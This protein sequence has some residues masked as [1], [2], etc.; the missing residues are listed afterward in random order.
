[1]ARL[2]L[3]LHP[4]RASLESRDLEL[5]EHWVYALALL[6]LRRLE[7]EPQCTPE[8]LIGLPTWPHTT[9]S[10][11]I[12]K[13]VAGFARR[14]PG[15]ITGTTITKRFCLEPRL[16]VCFEEPLKQVRHALFTS[17]QPRPTQQLPS[18]APSGLL[19][20]GIL[21][22]ERG[23]LRE[24]ERAFNQALDHPSAPFQ[25]FETLYW[26]IRALE[27]QGEW[28]QGQRQLQ[29]MRRS[30]CSTNALPAETRHGEALAFMAEA[31]LH[32]RLGRPEC[33]EVCYLEAKL[34][35]PRAAERDWG[36]LH[37]GLGRIAQAKGQFEL[38][39]ECYGL[40]LQCQMRAGWSWAQQAA[41]NDCGV[42]LELL[43]DQTRRADK[44]QRYWQRAIE[45]YLLCH[46]ICAAGDI[47]QDSACVEINLGSLHR[48]LRQFDMARDWLE[49]ALML[50][51]RAPNPHDQALALTCMGELERDLGHDS[52]A[53]SAFKAALLIAR[54][55][56]MTALEATC[57]EQLARLELNPT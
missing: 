43:G 9:K 40:S 15:L 51:E 24:A 29:R 44:R 11:S 41:L 25:R 22:L 27:L 49:R 50:A 26:L 48:K 1:M 10:S 21:H 5:S 2:L 45:H 38:A 53:K 36:S 12:G 54:R 7:G 20:M 57:L 47:G 42:V 6:G 52:A 55:Q 8:E 34:K 32:L 31:R 56:E 17:Q 19:S 18:A 33:A 30:L 3:R 46:G 23:R 4:P 39:L 16:E 14:H 35:L 13:S 37:N 28:E